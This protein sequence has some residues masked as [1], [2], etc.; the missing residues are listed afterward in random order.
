MKQTFLLAFPL[1]A[2]L[3]LATTGTVDRLG[4]ALVVTD[5]DPSEESFCE[6]EMARVLACYHR[7]TR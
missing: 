4:R 7:I 3:M 1:N 5:T 6:E 2:C